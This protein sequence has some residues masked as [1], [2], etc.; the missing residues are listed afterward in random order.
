MKIHD[1]NAQRIDDLKES[2][3]KTALCIG[4]KFIVNYSKPLLTE[5]FERLLKWLSPM[6]RATCGM[7]DAWFI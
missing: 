2:Q 6:L 3:K 4:I 1:N 7:Q 5:G